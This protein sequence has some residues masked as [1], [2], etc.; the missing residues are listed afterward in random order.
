MSASD[1][2][3]INDFSAD[4][5]HQRLDVLDVIRRHMQV[6]AIQHQQVGILSL[7]QGPE[8]AFTKRKVSIVARVRDQCFL[9]R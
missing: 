6:I 1:P 7:L 3:L 4:H 2:R 9:T 5:R 8:I